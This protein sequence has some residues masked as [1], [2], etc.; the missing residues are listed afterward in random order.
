MTLFFDFDGTLLD[1]KLRLYKL[2]QELVPQSSFSYNQYWDLKRN[3]VNHATIL[4]DYF[5]INNAQPF[6][7]E[8]FSR[9]E[10]SE[11]LDY[12][13]P[14]PGVSEYLAHLKENKYNLVLVTARQSVESI[15][16]QLSK[17]G[18]FDIFDKVLVTKQ[19]LSK[20]ELMRP[21]VVNNKSDYIIGDTGQDIIV[22]K[23]L[24]I[25]TVAVI[26]GFLSEEVLIEYNPDILL[27]SVTAFTPP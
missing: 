7:N 27:K 4:K 11:Y 6:L 24:G 15:N 25:F 22:G 9:I 23:E 1:S 16:Y 2:F 10:L 3:K 12:D 14:H 21:L 26:N 17:F 8:W 20:A 13:V 5:N 19:K 18:W